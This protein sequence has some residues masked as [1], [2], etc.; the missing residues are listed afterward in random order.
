MTLG[1]GLV[2]VASSNPRGWG[3]QKLGSGFGYVS[4]KSLRFIDQVSILN[5]AEW[6]RSVETSK[7]GSAIAIGDFST[8]NR[9]I[10]DH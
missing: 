7:S 8:I 9:T 1:G 3:A 4:S 10:H 2:Y 5:S 6:V